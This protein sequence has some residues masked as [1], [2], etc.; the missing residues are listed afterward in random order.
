MSANKKAADAVLSLLCPYQIQWLQDWSTFLVGEKSRRV[1]ISWVEALK[2]IAAAIRD[3]KPTDT[4]Y[5]S[6]GLDAAK[7]W[8]ENDVGFW[9]ELLGAAAEEFD[10]ILIDPDDNEAVQV[11]RVRFP[12]G[13][14]IY[15]VPTRPAVLRGKKGRVTLDEASSNEYLRE[16]LAAAPSPSFWKTGQISL[17]ST[18]KGQLNEFNQ[19]VEEVRSGAKKGNLHTIPLKR[20]IE[21]G[22]YRKV[23]QTNRIEWTEAEQDEWEE[24][25]RSDY[26]GNEGNELDCLPSADG[27]AFF[28]SEMVR[29]CAKQGKIVRWNVEPSFAKQTPERQLTA[30]QKWF[31]DNI[32]PLLPWI[33]GKTYIG[34]DFGR[35]SDLSAFAVMVQKQDEVSTPLLLEIRNCPFEVQKQL[36]V[37]LIKGLKGIKKAA[38][39]SN[40]IGAGIA[41]GVAH[42]YPSIVEQVNITQNWHSVSWGKLRQAFES[43]KLT[44]PNDGDVEKDLLLVQRYDAIPKIDKSARYKGADGLPRHGDSA[45][46]LA[47]AIQ[48]I[49]MDKPKR[50]LS[51][52]NATTG[53][54]YYITG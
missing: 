34:G 8:L 35:S 30:L 12:N 44:I 53:Q 41:E 24:E 29:G 28:T 4:Y 2:S 48:F 6:S 46:A 50:N 33:K 17:I 9:L 26:A 18:H 5:M 36:L 42:I 7:L 15:A 22:I 38:L 43:E 40:G 3:K 54:N 32:A 16:C 14:S 10:D 20:A 11:R 1:G 25:V 37:M 39:D 47:L 52:M 19:I 49:E 31:T 23:C 13:R 21:E 45:V 27:G 51:M